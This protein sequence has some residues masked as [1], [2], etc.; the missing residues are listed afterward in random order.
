MEHD[1]Y[2]GTPWPIGTPEEVKA[3]GLSLKRRHSCT[4]PDPDNHIK[5][6]VQWDVCQF[7]MPR[8]GGFKGKGPKYVGYRLITDGAEKNHAKQDFCS[9]FVFVETIQNRIISA[10]HNKD[11]GRDFERVAVIAQEGESMK[12]E[13][14]LPINYKGNVTGP[15]LHAMP[16]IADGL[17]KA[18]F[19]VERDDVNPSVDQKMFTFEIAVPKF[20]RPN[21]MGGLSFQASII[22]EEIKSDRTAEERELRLHEMEQ[23]E[24]AEKDVEPDDTLEMSLAEKP[25]RGR[26]AG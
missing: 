1:I 22:A 6:C 13:R 26:R 24:K 21:E 8:R 10:Q 2:E 20:P 12:V 9:C 25:E 17:E 15:F 23:A 3:A 16:W 18:G 14:S 4:K 11:M 5:G 19:T 7:N